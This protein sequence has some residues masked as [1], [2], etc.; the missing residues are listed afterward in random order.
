MTFRK[1]VIYCSETEFR[2]GEGMKQEPILC[3]HCGKDI[4]EFFRLQEKRKQA[5]KMREALEKSDPERKRRSREKSLL[6][7]K[8]W[9]ESRP[10]TVRAL[11]RAA[12]HSR[13]PEAYARQAKTLRETYRRKAVIFAEL[14]AEAKQ[15]GQEITPELEKVLKNRA[16]AIVKAEKKRGKK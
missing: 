4:T 7:L 16:A 1:S 10:K 13:T 9:R 8:Q 14:L 12:S 2:Q 15:A 3:P 11:A 6:A 5:E